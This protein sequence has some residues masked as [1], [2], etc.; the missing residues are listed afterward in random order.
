MSRI[1]ERNFTI[2]GSPVDCIT[3]AI[4]ALLQEPPDV[5]VS[6]INHGPN[7]GTDVIYSGTVAVAREAAL[8]GIPA[9]ACI[10]VRFYRSTRRC[11]FTNDG[12]FCGRAGP[13]V[14]DPASRENAVLSQCQSPPGLDAQ[15]AWQACRLGHAQWQDRVRFN[16]G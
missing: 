15:T 16:A 10:V 11:G 5:V 6:G 8:A 14:D 12:G 13:M 7:L 4:D 3:V 1:D 9:V 2:S